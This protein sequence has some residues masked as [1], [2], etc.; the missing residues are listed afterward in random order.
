MFANSDCVFTV[1]HELLY[2]SCVYAHS[3][4]SLLNGMYYAFCAVDYS[5]EFYQ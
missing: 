1:R 3:N 4:K 5:L 2:V